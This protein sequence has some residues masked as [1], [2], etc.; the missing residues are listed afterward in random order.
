MKFKIIFILTILPINLCSAN[1]IVFYSDSGLN[2]SYGTP[3]IWY[4][5]GNGETHQEQTTNRAHP[6]DPLKNQYIAGNPTWFG[7]GI[8]LGATVNLSSYYSSSSYL[9][10]Y[11]GLN[12]SLTG[13]ERL[14]I[15][16]EGPQGTNGTV[17]ITASGGYGF[18]NSKPGYWQLV[19]IP[20][21]SFS[22]VNW[23]SIYLPFKIT[24]ENLT[25]T[26]YIWWDYVLW[27]DDN[28]APPTPSLT[29]PPDGEKTSNQRPTFQW[30]SVSDPSGV[31]Y[32]I[33]I[34]SANSSPVVSVKGLTSTSFTPSS[35]LPD[36]TTFYW[37]V[38]SADSAGN[39]GSWSSSRKII[40]D[41]SY[42]GAP[43]LV[44]PLN[45]IVSPSSSVYFAWSTVTNAVAYNIQVS[46]NQSF[47]PTVVDIE[48][49]ASSYSRSLSPGK[50]YYWRVKARDSS[51]NYSNWSEVRNFYILPVGH[52]KF[53]VINDIGAA[54]YVGEYYGNS[55]SLTLSDDYS[56]YVEGIK[57][58]KAEFSLPNSNS[59]AG[60]YVEEGGA[61]GNETR[62]MVGFNTGYLY[63]WVKTSKDVEIGIRSN[64]IPA[65]NET[66]KVKLS[67]LGVQL[68][69]QWQ[70]VSIPMSLFRQKDSRLD[71]S[72]MVVYFNAAV[73]GNISGTG[74][75]TFWIDNVLWLSTAPGVVS[76]TAEL[77]NRSNNNPA[78]SITWSGITIGQTD[79]K[80][81]D[82][83]I[84]LHATITAST[85]LIQIYTDNKAS[86]AN[87]KYTGSGNPA[88]LVMVE[89]SS[90]TLKMCWRVTD[91][92]TNTLT[93]IQHPTQNYLYSQ[94]LG[95]GYRCFLW[96]KDK[97]TPNIPSENTT[98]FV[99][100]EDYVTV[101]ETTRGCQHAEGTWAFMPSPNYIYIGAKFLG[102]TTPATYKTNKLTLEAAIE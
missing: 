79:W 66:S 86:D 80:A 23:N 32:W 17:Y 4:W 64:N 26:L 21:S 51:Y 71:F 82:Q 40:I 73:M 11:L 27:T 93:I 22:G 98:Q 12:R 44:S 20:L 90:K 52:S 102:A 13:S 59:Y 14:K 35:D 81:A 37:W 1:Q 91:M 47:S 57:S 63:F 67:E 87:P 84:L 89:N 16:I 70:E 15:E 25:S 99:N 2:N 48:V 49:S 77:R 56:N 28:S 85:G 60:W 62:Y 8:Y 78:T 39:I 53:V 46:E 92:S 58:Q 50:T 34:A 55:G 9:R 24:A 65:G 6:Y 95:S 94:E 33:Y 30:S 97:N 101:W 31:K 10:F 75:G 7:C 29:Y 83:Y 76:M 69:N 68:N 5:S 42:I 61:G 72:Q 19:S 100:G 41:T 43:T 88:G 38:L 3:A 45:N 18:D 74:S 96:M 54:G 36:K